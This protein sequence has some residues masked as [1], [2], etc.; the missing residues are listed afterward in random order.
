MLLAAD[1][2]VRVLDLPSV[3]EGGAGEPDGDVV[4]TLLPLRRYTV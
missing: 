1:G 4:V 3:K 2:H